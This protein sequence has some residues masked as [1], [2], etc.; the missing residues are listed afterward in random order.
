MRKSH[1]LGGNIPALTPCP[2]HARCQVRTERC[3]TP[4]QPKQYEFSCALARLF[5]LTGEET[6]VPENSS[7]A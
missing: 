1:L 3:P 5:D 2:W 7:E 6:D 4:E